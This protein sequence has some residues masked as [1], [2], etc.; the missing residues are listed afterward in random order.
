M[1]NKRGILAL[2]FAL[3]MFLSIGISNATANTDDEND[4]IKH[5][6]FHTRKYRRRK[7]KK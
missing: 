3:F 5:S 4:K 7:I 1:K 6:V 2:A